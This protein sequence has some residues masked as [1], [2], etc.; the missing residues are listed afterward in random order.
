ML[1]SKKT[2]NFQRSPFYTFLFPEDPDFASQIAWS[3]HLDPLFSNNLERD[4]AL[5]WQVKQNYWSS[6][7]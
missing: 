4:S 1:E 5:S 2:K 7:T 6:H 3:S